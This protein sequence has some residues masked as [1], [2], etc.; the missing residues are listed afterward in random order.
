MERSP[1]EEGYTSSRMRLAEKDKSGQWTGGDDEEPGEYRGLK[2][3]LSSAARHGNQQI[4]ASPVGKHPFRRLSFLLPFV[5]LLREHLLEVS[6]P[7]YPRK[8]S[9]LCRLLRLQGHKKRDSAEGETREKFY[10]MTIVTLRTVLISFCWLS[11]ILC[12]LQEL[13][14][15]RRRREKGG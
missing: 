7:V 1:A 14:F 8:G 12:S 9:R 4:K 5:F 10:R 11:R 6:F 13:L 15:A 2:A 3:R